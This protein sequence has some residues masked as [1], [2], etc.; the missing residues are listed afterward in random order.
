MADPITGALLGG[1]FRLAPEALS[2]LDKKNERAHELALLNAQIEADKLRAEW[3]A[4]EAHIAAEASIDVELV[5]AL[6]AAQASQGKLTG[7]AW[8]D[9]LSQSVRPVLTYWWCIGLATAAMV[10]RIWLA[11]IS[12]DDLA[13]AFLSVWGEAEKAIVSSIISFWFLDRVLKQRA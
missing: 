8:V 10:A 2:W 7:V 13:T 9:A 12:G 11:V 5:K 4:Q 6:Q 1:L 3:R